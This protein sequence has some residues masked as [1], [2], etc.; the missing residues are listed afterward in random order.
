MA[1]YNPVYRNRIAYLE[2]LGFSADQVPQDGFREEGL[3]VVGAWPERGSVREE[4]NSITTTLIPWA[5]EATRAG[6]MAARQRDY[7]ETNADG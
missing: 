4:A 3:M 2:S 5:D 1:T 7:D 6:A